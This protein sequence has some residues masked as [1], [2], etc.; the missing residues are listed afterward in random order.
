MSKRR[1]KKAPLYPAGIGKGAATPSKEAKNLT[2][3]ARLGRHRQMVRDYLTTVEDNGES[4]GT[5]GKLARSYGL[6]PEDVRQFRDG[7]DDALAGTILAGWARLLGS[8]GGVIQADISTVEREWH[9]RAIYDEQE[10]VKRFEQYELIDD[11]CPEG[12][13]A[14]DAWADIVVTGSVGDGQ[15][16]GGGFDPVYMGQ[17][18]AKNAAVREAGRLINTRILPE[19]EKWKLARGLSK[20]GE[21]F[22][23]VG[24]AWEGGLPHLSRVVN[25]PVR[26]MH[27][28]VDSKGNIPADKAYLQRHPITN[29]IIAEFPIWKIAHFANK[30]ARGQRH[31]LSVFHATRRSHI[32]MEALHQAMIIRRLERA[33]L[34]FN[35]IIDVGHL[36][37]A[38]EIETAKETAR[39][40]HERQ[41]TVDAGRNHRLMKINMPVER[42]FFTAKRTKDSPAGIETLEGDANIGTIEDFLHFW[43]RWLAGLGPPPGHLGYLG[44]VQRSN[45]TEQHIAF[46]RKGRRMQIK[47]IA[48]LHHLYW[49]ELMLNGFDPRTIDYVI[50]PPSLGTKD[51]LLTAQVMLAHST[52]VKNIA[53]AYSVTK[54]VPSVQWMFKY[55]MGLDE[56]AIEDLQLVDVVQKAATDGTGKAGPTPGS[57][58]KSGESHNESIELVIAALEHGDTFSAM[59]SLQHMIQERAI[60]LRQDQYLNTENRQLLVKPNLFADNFADVVRMLGVKSLH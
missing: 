19:D 53:S 32:Q 22:E 28:N 42:D 35:H 40:T 43:N 50:W 10:R 14:L 33:P 31:G 49:L 46:A 41:R 54:Q 59:A 48:G 6:E 58:P 5:L 37:S 15:R 45:L 8:D 29:S 13:Q 17:D 52:V 25:M 60:A 55:L 24:I 56:Q 16:H 23:Q 1:E 11:S 7:R 4:S 9:D 18:R 30:K 3:E 51:E 12:H 27:V 47:F 21:E 44:G 38:D 36:G 2:P 34:R 57:Q 39:K 20:F 26:T